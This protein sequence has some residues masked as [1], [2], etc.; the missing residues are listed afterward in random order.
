MERYGGLW[1][2]MEDYG[3]QWMTMERYGGLWSAM[4]DYGALWV[5]MG[6]NVM[7]NEV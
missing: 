5:T 2:A 7:G 3:A 4:G 6:L 1:S